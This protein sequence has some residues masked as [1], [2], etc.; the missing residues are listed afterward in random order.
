MAT[1][2][3][4]GVASHAVNAA[5][6]GNV[7]E[8]RVL[9]R[10]FGQASSSDDAGASQPSA[11]STAS[12]LPNNGA[13]FNVRD[14][15]GR[16]PLHMAASY[17]QLDA[18]DWLLNHGAACDIQDTESGW[19]ALHRSLYF[20]QLSTALR[21]IA[22]GAG[23]YVR[24]KDDMTPLDIVTHNR[25]LFES[26]AY[27]DADARA[28]WL[29]TDSGDTPDLRVLGRNRTVSASSEADDGPT[30]RSRDRPSHRPYVPERP[31]GG[32]TDSSLY[33]VTDVYS[34]GPNNANY[35]LGH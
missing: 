2:L 34:W 5:I 15:R 33:L 30:T 9:F 4:I 35:T 19:T 12:R 8:L 14:A 31:P 25:I 18:L 32:A 17:G 26:G 20:G 6:H 11:S 22:G 23:L 28:P 24:D 3:A 13:I 7:D 16:T 27:V 29:E 21:L 10:R 1:A